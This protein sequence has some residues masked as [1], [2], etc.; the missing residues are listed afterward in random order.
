MNLFKRAT[1]EQEAFDYW[2]A[3]QF[4]LSD[5]VLSLTDNLIKN[6]MKLYS[7]FKN[8]KFLT[9]M[10]YYTFDFAEVKKYLGIEGN[11]VERAGDVYDAKFNP[12]RD[13][14]VLTLNRDEMKLRSKNVYDKILRDLSKLAK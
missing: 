6:G 13:K 3:S 7:V 14:S 11:Y 2:S 12:K 1:S 10:R 5:I 9:L 4:E 8:E